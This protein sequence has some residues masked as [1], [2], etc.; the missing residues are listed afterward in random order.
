MKS[1]Q[2]CILRINIVDT[3]LQTTTTTQKNYANNKNNSIDRS[4]CLR[5]RRF[6]RTDQLT[7]CAAHVY[8]IILI[9]NMVILAYTLMYLLSVDANGQKRDANKNCLRLF[10]NLVWGKRN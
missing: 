2:F 1:M 4:H 7:R 8:V 3:R 9:L 5:Q 10:L 6:K